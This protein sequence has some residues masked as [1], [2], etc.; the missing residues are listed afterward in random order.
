MWSTAFTILHILACVFLVVVVL[1]QTGKGTDVNAVFGGSSQTIFGS[2]GA[3]NFLTKLTTATA[4]V[5]M[6]TS[7]FLT[8]GIT[9]QTTKSIFDDTP[10]PPAVPT[11][12]TPEQA[13]A[14]PGGAPS[15]KSAEAPAASQ[16]APAAT[17]PVPTPPSPSSAAPTPSATVSVIP[18]EAP[19]PSTTA[20]PADV[21]KTPTAETK[22]AENTAKTPAPQAAPAAPK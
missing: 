5:F 14:T 21:T 15:E 9:K 12:A 22:P 7:L 1:L 8:Y 16:T 4:A 13:P 20:S 10:A 3:G 6:V 11:P 19:K 18:S 17:P 2:S